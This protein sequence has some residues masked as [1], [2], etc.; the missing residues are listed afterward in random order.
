MG[1][2]FIGGNLTTIAWDGKTLAADQQCNFDETPMPVNKIEKVRF[3]GKKAYAAFSGMVSD[4]QELKRWLKRPKG[5]CPE[6]DED[7][8]E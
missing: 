1:G 3:K 2:F 6:P 8:N 5:K 4:F 7:K